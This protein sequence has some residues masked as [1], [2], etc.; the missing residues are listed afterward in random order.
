MKE[1]DQTVQSSGLRGTLER[2][3]SEED[4]VFYR[5]DLITDRG[6]TVKGILYLDEAFGALPS[7]ETDTG[8]YPVMLTWV[9]D[10]E[11]DVS[12]DEA[13]A[14]YAVGDAVFAVTERNENRIYLQYAS[15]KYTE[16]ADQAGDR[17]FSFVRQTE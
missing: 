11:R 1:I 17:Q 4:F 13:E 3:Q 16:S 9:L 7:E 10:P 15:E 5:A 14:P 12:E 6:E 2:L 8:L